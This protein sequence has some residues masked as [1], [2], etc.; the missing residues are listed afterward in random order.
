LWNSMV[1]IK[2]GMMMQ[3]SAFCLAFVFFFLVTA[4]QNY[5]RQ[6]FR[7]PM[8]IPM[9]LV[10]NFGEIRA[11]H[12]HMGLDIRT[13]QRVNL[14]V[15]AAAE[16]YISRIVVEPGGF[17][18][19]IYI[20]HPNGF[21]TLY[22]HMNAF[23][24]ALATW[25]KS[26]Q[27]EQQSWR[28]NLTL[29]PKLFPVSKGDF[30]G[31]SGSTGA[32]EGPHVHFEIRDTKT[33]KCLNPLLFGFPLPDAV[34][35]T[36]TRLAMYDRNRST[37]LQSPQ[38]LPLRRSG[39]V[40]VP[41]NGNIRSGS[42]AISFAIGAVDR[43][44]G[45]TN[46]NGIYAATMLVDERPISEFR[47]DNIG[48]DET[49]YINAQLDLPYKTRGGGSLQHI[50]PLPGANPVAYDLEGDGALHLRDTLPHAVSIKVLDA[51][52]NAS[53]IRFTVRYDPALA[54]T[55]APLNGP[56]LI[57]NQVNVF[58]QPAFE[59]FTSELSIYDTIPV[60][61]REDAA[62]ADGAVSDRHQFMSN[63]YP[64]HDSVTVRIK[65]TE[66]LTAAQR[67]RIVIKNTW[68]SRI[69]VHRAEWQNGWLGA[70]FR[71]FGI[72]QAFLDEEPPTVNAPAANLS[73]AGSIVF[74]PKDNFNTIRSFRAE[75]DGAWLRFTNDKGRSWAYAFDEHFPRGTHQLRLIIEDEAGNVM[76]KTYTVTR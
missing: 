62:P 27:Y 37:Y 1:L 50:T 65:P 14:P 5:P 46:P 43:F 33:E 29:P 31:Y 19:A 4:A 57:P 21:T 24:P 13:Q 58:E 59:V 6:Y 26:Q 3:R 34:A 56:L 20:A 18:Q 2:N 28:V 76:D 8:N 45:S 35:P 64:S 75:L 72:Y 16:G 15:H 7:N 25:V 23:F 52:G 12:W 17:G 51:N 71:Q 22:A 67:Q 32:S 30:I 60:V 39:G 38:M 47:L 42:N 61:Y 63:A 66:D 68:G 44:S 74:V 70:R 9:Q 10:A 69:F 48:Y 41:A 53:T 73:K 36:L 54:K 40:Y 55:Y 11:N 49:R